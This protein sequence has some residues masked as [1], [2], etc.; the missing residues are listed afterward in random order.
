MIR[1][2][3]HLA[4]LPLPGSVAVSQALAAIDRLQRAS[5]LTVLCASLVERQDDGTLEVAPMPPEHADQIDATA[6][7]RLLAGTLQAHPP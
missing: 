3:H 4:V 5:A 1:S 6:W 7:R 2:D